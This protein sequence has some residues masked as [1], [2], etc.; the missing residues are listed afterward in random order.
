MS[1]DRARSAGER[2]DTL[3]RVAVGAA[4]WIRAAA[5]GDGRW[6]ANPDARGRSALDPEPFSLYAGA[7]GIVLFFLELAAATGE[8]EYLRDARAGCRYLASALGE[9]ADVTFHHG[10][11]G[12]AVALCEAGWVL[13]D[14]VAEEAAAAAMDR[15]ARSA[16]PLE[17]G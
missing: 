5:S 10:L 1:V 2:A 16:R 3:L 12:I 14:G 17:G 6:L 7:P 9:V 11:S 8:E 13:G 4:R 15:V